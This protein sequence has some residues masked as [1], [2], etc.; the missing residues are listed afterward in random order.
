MVKPLR[1]FADCFRF[2]LE[3]A[4]DGCSALIPSRQL[5]HD[6]I[7]TLMELAGGHDMGPAII[8]SGKDQS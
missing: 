8:F 5:M 2:L 1:H 6:G 4:A 3:S 7:R